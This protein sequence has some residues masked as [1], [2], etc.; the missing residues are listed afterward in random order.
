VLMALGGWFLFL[1]FRR[2][3]QPFPRLFL[4]ATA[5]AAPLGFVAV[6]AGWTVTEVGR[7]P[8]IIYGVLRT[9]DA[10]TPMPGLVWPL[11]TM[12]VVYTLLVFVTVAVLKRLVE[13]TERNIALGAGPLG[14]SATEAL[15]SPPVEAPHA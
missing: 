6:E 2:R 11:L 4:R 12:L 1:H 7:Q 8:W 13:A 9:K 14:S 10:L 3:K 5:L 15:V